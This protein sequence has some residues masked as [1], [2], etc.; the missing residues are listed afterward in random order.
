MF[1]AE[2]AN[3]TDALKPKATII[4]QLSKFKL[5][6]PGKIVR[7]KKHLKQ[8]PCR[9]IYTKEGIGT[10]YTK[11]NQIETAS[12]AFVASF[13]PPTMSIITVKYHSSKLPETHF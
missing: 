9:T 12:I 11:T 13:M 8:F 10:R 1:G 3:L 6:H 5:P 4:T 2:V 7:E